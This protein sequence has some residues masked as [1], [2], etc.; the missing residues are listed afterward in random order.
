MKNLI[1]SMIEELVLFGIGGFIYIGLEM[2]WRGYSHWTM[3]LLGGLCFTLM[4]AINNVYTYDMSIIKQMIMSSIIITT[5]EFITGIVV[6]IGL[7]WNVWDYSNL[8]FNIYGQVCVWFI[9]LWF[10]LSF[11][12]IVVDDYIRY[13]LF[14]EEKP[15]YKL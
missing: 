10:I 2:L 8:P 5:L 9:F 7:G 6:N 3:F 12:G 13:W 15:H 1:K 11:I 14:D 4:G